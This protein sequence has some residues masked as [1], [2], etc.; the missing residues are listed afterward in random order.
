MRREENFMVLDLQWVNWFK[1]PGLTSPQLDGCSSSALAA[2]SVAASR[3]DLEKVS[4]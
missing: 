1:T 2:R 4:E 3:K